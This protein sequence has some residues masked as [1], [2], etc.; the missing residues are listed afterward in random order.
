MSNK[1]MAILNSFV[2]DIFNHITTEAS[3]LAVG[4][5]FVGGTSNSTSHPLLLWIEMSNILC[6]P[7][8]KDLECAINGLIKGEVGMKYGFG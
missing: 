6:S 5:Q 3:K 8:H 7:M 1:A 2:N 4:L